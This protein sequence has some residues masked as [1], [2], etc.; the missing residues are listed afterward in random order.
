MLGIL[1][2]QALCGRVDKDN[3][4]VTIQEDNRLIGIFE[5]PLPRSRSR[6]FRAH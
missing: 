5:K 4:P 3:A 2:K 1:T 6:A